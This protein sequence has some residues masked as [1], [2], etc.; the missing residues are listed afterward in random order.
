MCC[1]N[2]GY[3]S[4]SIFFSLGMIPKFRI[5]I[6]ELLDLSIVAYAI[7]LIRRKSE[8]RP[9]AWPQTRRSGTEQHQ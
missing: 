4:H 3:L 5:A 8:C 2:P 1:L 9:V 6:A 7:D